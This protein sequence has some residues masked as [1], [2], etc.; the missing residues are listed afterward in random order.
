M[1]SVAGF[2][3]FLRQE[4][5]IDGVLQIV[6]DWVLNLMRTQNSEQSTVQ[7]ESHRPLSCAGESALK[8]FLVEMNLKRFIPN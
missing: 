8:S 7:N 2:L 4:L 6:N 1:D 3:I 5:M